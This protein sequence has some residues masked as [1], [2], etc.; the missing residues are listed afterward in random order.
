MTYSP[1]KLSSNREVFDFVKNHL[2][3]QGERAIENN[4]CLYRTNDGLMCAA[5]CLISDEMYDESAEGK[6]ADTAGVYERIVK[7][8]GGFEPAQALLYRLQSIHDGY[9][10]DEWLSQLYRIDVDIS[11]GFYS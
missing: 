8:I 1:P 9:M 4:T 6:R 10:P 3:T 7:S 11:R 5:G 2:L